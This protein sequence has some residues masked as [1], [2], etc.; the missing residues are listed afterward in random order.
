MTNEVAIQY[1]SDGFDVMEPAGSGLVK[2]SLLRFK[3]DAYLIGGTDHMPEDI[4]ELTV[5]SMTTCWTRWWNEQPTHV[6][7]QPGQQHP[8]RDELGDLDE[9]LWQKGKDGTRC[10][11]WADTRHLVLVHDASAATFTFVTSTTGGRIAISELKDAIKLRR[12]ARP[13]SY[14][15]V[16]LETMTMKTR[17]GDRLRPH[18]KITG[19]HEPEAQAP[20]TPPPYMAPVDVLKAIRGEPTSAEIMSDDIPF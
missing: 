20:A 6:V 8:R 12:R 2:G 13:R 15:I 5:V 10:D 9:S 19:W 11:P 3:D 18:F 1:D 4:T 14:P 17:F 7:T 16:A